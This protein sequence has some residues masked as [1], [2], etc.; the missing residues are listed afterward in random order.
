MSMYS[1]GSSRAVAQVEQLI[2]PVERSRVLLQ[3]GEALDLECSRVR[4]HGVA[5]PSRQQ[6]HCGGWLACI[7]RGLAA[8]SVTRAHD[9]SSACFNISEP[10]VSPSRDDR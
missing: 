5:V 1:S 8:V 10:T 4:R 7:Q 2:G 6:L 9:K 3:C